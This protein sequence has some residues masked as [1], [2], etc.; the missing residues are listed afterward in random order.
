MKSLF[1]SAVLLTG[2]VSAA[3]AGGYE[4]FN[5]GLAALRRGQNDAAIEVLTRAL[6]ADDLPADLRPVA[7]LTRGRA[8]R[9]NGHLDAAIADFAQAISLKPDFVD[10]YAGRGDAYD[11]AG[12]YTEALADLNVV[13]QQ[14]P[15][16]AWAYFTRGKLQFESARYAEASADF[17]RA[18]ELEP[19]SPYPALVRHISAVKAGEQAAD[20]LD[21][22]AR[23]LDLSKWPGPVLKLY[24]GRLT[25]EAVHE[26]AGHDDAA[27][28]KNQNCEADFYVGEWHLLAG[29]TADAKSLLQRAAANCP[30]DFVEFDMAAAE[31]KRLP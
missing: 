6:A 31:L 26:A 5:A 27:I 17:K 24:L 14:R 12:R 30:P 23:K 7:L 28:Q 15:N 16:S 21:L 19:L 3:L 8:Y 11:R 2:I 18:A 22:S 29:D 13:M 4:D 9:A 20:D 25:P 10:A 1:A